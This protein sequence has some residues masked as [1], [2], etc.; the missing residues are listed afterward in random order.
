[1]GVDILGEDVIKVDVLGVE[2][3]ALILVCIP[4][5][6]SPSKMGLLLKIRICSNR[7]KFLPTRVDSHLK[8]RQKY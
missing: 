8:G 1:M 7:S 6:H 4:G 3:M 2:V 5:G